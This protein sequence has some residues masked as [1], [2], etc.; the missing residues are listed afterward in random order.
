[1]NTKPEY[2]V[3]DIDALIS[4]RKKFE[5]FVYTPVDVAIS[6]LKTRK[7]DKDVVDS[8][9]LLLGNDI[10]EPF[11]GNNLRAVI[12][13]QITTSNYEIRRFVHIIDAL[14]ELTP[15]FGEYRDDKFTSKNEQKHS[16]G[17]ILFHKN[18]NSKLESIKIIDLVDADGK[19]MSE[20]ETL[21]GQPLIEFHHELIQ[22]TYRP[23]DPNFFYNISPWLKQHGGDA[24]NYYK[25][26][27]LWFVKDAI[28]FENFMPNETKELSFTKEVF[29]PAFIEIFNLT[30]KKPLI[31]N[32]LPT[33]IE[34][35]KFWFSHPG[36][37][38]EY[39]ESKFNK[40]SVIQ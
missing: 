5:E 20:I 22:K 23:I 14:E 27:L 6:E 12:F 25:Q 40:G 8:T 3:A 15:L 4:D 32:L 33:A 24:K 17:K 38:K 10:P 16:W 30:K 2:T 31:V 1:M 7:V 37:V 11:L 18:H 13:R 19:K 29:L 9:N 36:N 26:V 34:N 21:W 28:L 35:E 39:I